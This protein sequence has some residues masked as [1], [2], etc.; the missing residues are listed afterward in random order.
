MFG[1]HSRAI[2]LQQPLNRSAPLA[3]GLVGL[4]LPLNSGPFSGGAR[5]LDLCRNNHA[6]LVGG[7]TWGGGLQRPGASATLVLDGSDD[8]ASVPD[9]ADL[10]FDGAATDWSIG[11]CFRRKTHDTNDGL[12][13]KKLSVASTDPGYAFMMGDGSDLPNFLW[14][15]SGASFRE[16]TATTAITD[17]AIWYDLA[18]TYSLSETRG[19]LF[20]NG[21]QE[22]TDNIADIGDCSNAQPLNFGVSAGATNPGNID[23]AYVFLYHRLM[24]AEDLVEFRLESL[25]GYP[26]LLNRL[27]LPW[28]DVP[29]AAG[30]GGGDLL[31]RMMGEGLY[32]SSGG[33]AV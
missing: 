2:N 19:R 9:S 22:A 28:L 6:A 4:W 33:N 5:L 24:T 3:R 26:T 16:L 8:Y 21:V 32:A 18:V 11:I 17:P 14:H 25:R 31:L 27:R 23:I 1:R 20:V 13:A 10:E 12:I 29:A 30:G 15:D 7:A